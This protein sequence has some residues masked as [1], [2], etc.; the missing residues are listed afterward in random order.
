MITSAFYRGKMQV[1]PQWKSYPSYLFPEFPN[2]LS[3]VGHFQECR[4]Y[5]FNLEIIQV[6]V[7]YLMSFHLCPWTKKLLEFVQPSLKQYN[8]QT[9]ENHTQQ[10]RKNQENGV[11][12]S[13]SFCKKNVKGGKDTKHVFK[14]LP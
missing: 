8:N 1:F 9:F 6:A 13:C 5:N 10:K 11:V 2:R 7:P 3:R 12:S 14:I 4:W